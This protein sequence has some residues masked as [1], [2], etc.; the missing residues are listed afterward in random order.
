MNAS[1]LTRYTPS[2]RDLDSASVLF[3]L[4]SAIGE[5]LCVLDTETTGFGRDA[6][7]L[8]LAYLWVGMDGTLERFS[9]LLR[10]RWSIPPQATNVHGISFDMVRDAP[11]FDAVADAVRFAFEHAVIS[12]F[13]VRA[14]DVPILQTW[15]N[16]KP[17]VPDVLDVRDVWRRI[18]RTQ[19]GKLGDLA[20]HFGVEPGAAHQ[21]MG[22][23]ITTAR[24]LAKMVQTY[25]SQTI[26]ESL[27]RGERSV[28]ASRPALI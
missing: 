9:C 24:V 11:G 17:C 7:V 12:G 6:E 14:Y 3:D 19:K 2:D 21:G 25:G 28:N 15:T 18:A 1:L 8:E 20:D 5:N 23:V 27:I 13:N 26:G 4:V 16:P 10:P 22:D